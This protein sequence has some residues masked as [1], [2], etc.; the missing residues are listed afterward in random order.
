MSSKSQSGLNMESTKSVPNF[1]AFKFC[2]NLHKTNQDLAAPICH[3]FPQ[4]DYF[5]F[6]NSRRFARQVH[7]WALEACKYAVKI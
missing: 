1:K 3:C 2:Y 4:P 5:H 7:P 6:H